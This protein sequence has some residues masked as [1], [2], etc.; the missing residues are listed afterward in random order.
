MKLGSGFRS[1]E[2]SRHLQGQRAFTINFAARLVSM[3]FGF[4]FQV[5]VVKILVPSQ[6]AVYAVAFAAVF[7]GGQL[8][9]LGV[10]ETLIRFVPWGVARGD[11][12]GLR[13]LA[14][15]MIALRVTSILIILAALMFG[16]RFAHVFLPTG[17]TPFT[18]C[19]LAIWLVSWMLYANAFDL[20]QSLM[21]QREVAIVIISDAVIRLAALYVFYLLHQSVDA[22]SVIGIYALTSTFSL[23]WL[24]YLV[25]RNVSLPLGPAQELSVGNPLSFALGRYMSSMTW[26]VTSPSVVRLVAASGLNVLPLAGFSFVQGL[27]AS[28]QRAFPGLILLQSMEPILLR[29]LAEGV[30][31]E[32]ILSAIAVIFKLQL[33]FILTICIASALA[34]PT[35]ITLLARPEYA[36]Y[37]Y[38]LIV[39]GVTEAIN[40]AYRILEVVS[41]AV[42]KQAIFFWIWPFGVLSV[43][44]IYFTVHTWGIWAALFFPLLEGVLRI[45]SLMFFFRRDGMQAALDTRR[46]MIMIISALIAVIT[47]SFLSPGAATAIGD[48]LAATGGIVVF[49]LLVCIAKPLR[50]LEDQLILKMIPK[51]WKTIRM[52]ADAITRP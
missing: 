41:S 6:F 33:F 35:I 47:V 37:W 28:L 46:S 50:P 5:S 15:C 43:L 9:S 42:A 52:F 48:L 30:R 24:S 22:Q 40:S 13:R 27:Y 18:L 12:H 19:I 17:F 14:R 1:T 10:G 32:K 21:L 8:F 7:V 49:V 23:M 45:G 38:I 39:L 11:V 31:Y 2:N 26:L 3:F 20:A 51:D 36:S 44:C 29:G 16:L 34:G 4:G 25:W